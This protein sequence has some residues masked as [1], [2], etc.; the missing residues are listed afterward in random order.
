MAVAESAHQSDT[1]SFCVIRITVEQLQFNWNRASRLSR[2]R[3]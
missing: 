2:S 1:R 3:W